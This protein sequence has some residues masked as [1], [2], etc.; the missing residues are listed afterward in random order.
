MR[1]HDIQLHDG[2]D[3]Y[4]VTAV[5]VAS[6]KSV[7]WIVELSLLCCCRWYDFDVCRLGGCGR[8]QA[9]LS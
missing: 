2:G 3:F 6:G 5:E 9:G 8:C 4:F 1:T 7:R